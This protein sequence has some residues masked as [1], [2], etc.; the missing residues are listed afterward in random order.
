[1]ISPI[2]YAIQLMLYI[3]FFFGK[4]TRQF[5]AQNTTNASLSVCGDNLIN[6]DIEFPIKINKSLQLN[7]AAR[8]HQSND[9]NI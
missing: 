7:Q 8:L 1:M 2:W 9:Y 4:S 5:S 6:K 3:F